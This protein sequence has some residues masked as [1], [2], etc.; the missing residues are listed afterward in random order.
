MADDG[1][2]D[3]NRDLVR[4]QFDAVDRG[5]RAAVDALHSDDYVLH[6]TYGMPGGG[7]FTG[8]AE[9]A[10]A[11]ARMIGL[12]GIS[13]VSLTELVADGPTRGGA[14]VEASGTTAAGAAWSMPCV[15]LIEVAGDKIVDTRLFFL[16][17]AALRDIAQERETLAS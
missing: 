15:E 3:A 6:L 9:I 10:A 1:R 11:R 2:T 7:S 5:D 14:V 8:A 12:L 13:K 16:D 4:R 17:T